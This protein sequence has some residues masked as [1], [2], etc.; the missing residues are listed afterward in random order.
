MA[1][2]CTS[3]R[4]KRVISASLPSGI[5]F[6]L[7]RI[8]MTSSMKSSA[9][10]R[11]SRMWARSCAFFSSYC[12]RRSTTS[13]WNRMY[14]CRICFS[15]SVRGCPST[16]ASMMTPNVTCICVSEYRLFRT[17]CGEASRL[18]SMTMCMPLRSEWS[19]MFEMP[20][21]RFSLTRSAMLSISRA[22]LTWY[23]SSETTIWNRP[24]GFST[25]S[26]RARTW[27]LPR[28]VP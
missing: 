8:A 18:T 7:R 3:S 12:V 16:I 26:A 10:I 15:V 20:S 23:G 14:S 2:A 27:I 6:E 21:S 17:I 24:F 4:P 13:L 19:S 9:I 28:P 5:D 11:P 22:L 1:C 25:I